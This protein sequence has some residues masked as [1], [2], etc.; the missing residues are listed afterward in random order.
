VATLTGFLNGTDFYAGSVQ[1]NNAASQF[2]KV[3]TGTL[4][5]TGASTSFVGVLSVRDGSLVLQGGSG[6]LTNGGAAVGGGQV[7]AGA[8][9]WLNNATANQGDRLQDNGTFTLAGG[10]L[11]IDGNSSA[12]VTSSETVGSLRV[13]AG[14]ATVQLNPGGTRGVQLNVAGTLTESDPTGVVFFRG[15]TFG[16]AAFAAGANATANVAVG[17]PPALVGGGGSAATR[18][19]ILPYG[20]GL[21]AASGD[22]NTFVTYDTTRGTVRPLDP[23]TEL[24]PSLGLNPADNVL[25]TANTSVGSA[26]TANSLILS[27]TRALA[28]TAPLTVTAGAL[29]QVGS[30]AST[31]SGS[32]GSLLFGPAGASP[33]FVTAAGA[34]DAVTLSVPVTAAHFSKNG[35]G[36]V[37]VTA[38]VSLAAGG[39]VAI[40]LGTLAVQNNGTTT[41]GGFAA[42]GGPITYQVSKGVVPA[43]GSAGP[44]LDVSGVTAGLVLG[45]GQVLTGGGAGFAATPTPGQPANGTVAGTVTVNAGGTVTPSG[46]PGPGTLVVG[47][48]VWKPG[49]TYAWQ[50]SSAVTDAG[51]VSPYTAARLASTAGTLDLTSLTAANRFTIKVSSLGPDNAAGAVYDFDATKS[52]TWTIATFGSGATGGIINP[53][54]GFS[55]ALFT[56]DTSGFAN[57]PGSTQFS[58]MEPDGHTLQLVYVPV[59]EPGAVLGLAGLGLAAL[60]RVRRSCRE[61]RPCQGAG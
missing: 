54:G 27:G 17:T 61:S 57:A 16:A 6:R 21:A 51:F 58:V 38:P 45:T 30:G 28:L 35:S 50:V 19:S 26:T 47:N 60:R 43:G 10:T 31:V 25:L 13:G 20:V 56:V 9:L 34:A 11:Q 55:P 2:A 14:Q 42:T 4:T 49:G 18:Q 15:A 22:P 46:L 44:A 48:M 36:T 37:T 12:S 29:M 59:P 24:A 8:T 23:A 52:A 53:A 40:N 41:A 5:L 7:L 1:A 33:A 32:G 39:V 3:G